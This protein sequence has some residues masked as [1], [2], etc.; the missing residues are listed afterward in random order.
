MY[1]IGKFGGG[2][3]I[4]DTQ[5]VLVLNKSI[6]KILCMFGS[7]YVYEAM[8]EATFSSLAANPNIDHHYHYHKTVSN[9]NYDANFA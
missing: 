4:V 3:W 5:E 8:Y 7:T 2:H 9:Q 1:Q 6:P